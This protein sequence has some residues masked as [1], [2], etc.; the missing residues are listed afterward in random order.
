[1]FSYLCE[2]KNIFSINYYFIFDTKSEEN[3]FFSYFFFNQV[4]Y[5]PYSLL[6]PMSFSYQGTL[7]LC[8]LVFTDPEYIKDDA[9]VNLN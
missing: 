9:L 8:S 7:S 6:H 5:L 4:D 1:M 2:L 3:N